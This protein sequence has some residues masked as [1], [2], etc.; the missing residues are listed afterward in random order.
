VPIL[1]ARIEQDMEDGRRPRELAGV[2]LARYLEDI[3]RI[4]DVWAA[5]KRR[6]MNTSSLWLEGHDVT[7][8]GR[9]ADVLM[10]AFQE[11]LHA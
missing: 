10:K 2:Q 5:E 11:S 1:Q 8:V 7:D 9:T 4:Y 6:L 3:G